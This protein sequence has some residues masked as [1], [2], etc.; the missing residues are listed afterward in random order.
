M[1]FRSCPTSGRRIGLRSNRLAFAGIVLFNFVVVG[2]LGGA[3]NAVYYNAGQ[4]VPIVSSDA[5]VTIELAP[6]ADLKQV[7]ADLAA[8]G[9]TTLI[10]ASPNP[11]VPIRLVPVSGGVSAE[12]M[13]QLRSIAGVRQVSK[14]YVDPATKRNRIV[15]DRM[16]VAFKEALSEAQAGAF[17]ANY[18]ATVVRP[19]E[20]L[21]GT[22]LIKL[23]DPSGDAVAV[24]AAIAGDTQVAYCHPDFIAEIQPAAVTITDTYY[25]LQWHLHNTGQGGATVDADVDWPEAWNEVTGLPQLGS[26]VIAIHDEGQQRSHED[27]KAGYLTGYDF[28]DNDTDPTPGF[29]GENHGTAVTGVA[30]ARLNGFGVVG[31]APTARWMGLRWGYTESD[32]ADAFLF[33]LANGADVI[34]NSWGLLYTEPSDV[35]KNAIHQAATTGRR[36]KGMVVI[37]SSGNGYGTIDFVSPIAGLADVIAVGASNCFDIRSPYSDTGPEL[38]VVAPSSDVDDP[39]AL[40]ITTTDVMD[41]PNLRLPTKGYNEGGVNIYGLPEIPDG[42]YTK[43]FGGTSSSAPLVSGI[44]GLIVGINPNLY[45]DQVRRILEHT[46]DQIDLAGGTYD[47]VTGHSEAYGYGR[48]NAYQAVI[49]AKE[50]S[51]NGNKT[52][53]PPVKNL[54]L[55]GTSTVLLTW[56]NPQSLPADEVASVMVIHSTLPITWTPSGMRME[57][58]QNY[59]V[60]DYVAPGVQ[61]VQNSMSSTYS[62]DPGQGQHYYAVF[63]R[64]PQNRWSWGRST[65]TVLGPKSAPTASVY[66]T[67]RTGPGPL[68]VNFA[69][70]AFDPDVENTVFSYVW[71]FGDGT[72]AG[73]VQSVTHKYNLVGTYMAKVTVT[74]GTGLSGQAQMMIQ[75]TEAVGKPPT[76]RISIDPGY[77]A[78][79]PA[80]HV[81]RLRSVVVAAPGTT[82]DQILWTFG[83]GATAVGQVVEH[84]YLNAGAYPVTVRVTDSKGQSA[85]ASLM[86]SVSKAPARTSDT[87]NADPWDLACLC[88]TCGSCGSA[89]T[90]MLVATMLG[91]GLLHLG[92]RRR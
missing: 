50:S 33:A 2:V 12:K 72:G 21:S 75:V 58:P 55:T 17:L 32:L 51:A 25:P 80:P 64:N 92:R 35:L 38:C 57:S 54:S 20:G 31:S 9:M 53:P 65:G 28:T 47:I 71:D 74:D 22:Y 44:A 84:T 41:E 23:S 42:N 1:T 6:G 26:V 37:F 46:A 3:E 27:L 68:T 79:G 77:S 89:G 63:V 15:T 8:K 14:L 36:G 45:V 5:M 40:G 7:A 85:M 30:A 91:W 24:A 62:A 66:A 78:D 49:A 67:P 86:C 11:N 43:N 60:G 88:P 10:L 39:F 18:G 82:I 90:P 83:D 29:P 48:A 81:I 59:V 34:N 13:A 76:V 16:V 73:N 87:S 61:V 70:G 52:W 56:K 19:M 4:A 69:A